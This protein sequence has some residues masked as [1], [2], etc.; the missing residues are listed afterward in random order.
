MPWWDR[1]CD[2]ALIVGTFIHGLGNYE[3]MRNDKEIPFGRRTAQFIIADSGSAQIFKSFRV[4]TISSRKV[5]DDAFSADKFKAQAEA[6][7]AVAATV[8]ES[9]LVADQGSMIKQGST[10]H[11][12]N[13]NPTY[14]TDKPLSFQTTNARENISQ[15]LKET[16]HFS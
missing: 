3:A 8:V 2:L 7:E 10:P 4:A 13:T 16:N 5:F 14:N 9:K 1:S 6:H 11:D 15:K 12:S